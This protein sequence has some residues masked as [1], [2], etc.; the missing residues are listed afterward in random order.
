MLRFTS[1]ETSATELAQEALEENAKLVIA[2]GGDGTLSEVASVVS[3]TDVRF[4]AIPLGTAN[5]LCHVLYGMEAKA[6][7]VNKPCTAIL[8]GHS[9][10]IDIAYCNDQLMLLVMGIGFEQQMI[11]Y[12][13]REKKNQSGQFAY[14]N[15]FFNALA[16]DEP[17]ELNYQIDDEPQQTLQT[18]S[19][20]VANTAP[21]TTVL[22]QGGQEPDPSDGLL[23]ITY[24]KGSESFG[25]KLLALSDITLS[26]LD[27]LEQAHHFNY[28]TGKRVEI[29]ANQ[30]INYVVDGEPYEAESLVVKIEKDALNVCSL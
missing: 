10:P 19:F 15:G 12:A 29:H 30:P 16:S 18:S 11:E 3:S 25:E 8:T 23:H 5:T 17:I 24:L 14:L 27:L 9:K 28:L 22:A 20:V 13:A 6:S 2:A 7:P 26:A 21:F 4:G 1:K